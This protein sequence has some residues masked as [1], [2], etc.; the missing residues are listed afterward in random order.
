MRLTAQM[1]ALTCRFMDANRLQELETKVGALEG[2]V[3]SLRS[4]LERAK[5]ENTAP[6]S[7][8]P[9]T[10]DTIATKV[11]PPAPPPSLTLTQKAPT[12]QLRTESNT[13]FSWEWLIGGNIIGKVGIVTLI[14]STALFM[15]YALDQG[16]LSE[17]VRLIMLQGAFAALGFMSYRLY[18]KEYRY[19]PE[20]L[21]I[22]ALAA[23]TIAIYSAHFVYRFLGR[24]ETMAMMFALMAL[25]LLYARR[26]R[27]NAL[28]MIL[29]VAFFIL[30]IVHSRGINEAKIYFTYLT[31]VN[32]LFI[33]LN[34]LRG[35][36]NAHGIWI[37]LL[38]NT[39]SVLGW[40]NAYNEY[41]TTPL[42]FCGV[43]LAALLYAAHVAPWSQNSGKFFRPAAIISV[44]L[45]Y[46]TMIAS[47]VNLNRNFSADILAI[48]YIAQAAI[49]LIVLQ[50]LPERVR[51]APAA[52]FAVV[53][54]MALGIMLTMHGPAER[55]VVAL[56][57]LLAM[58]LAGKYNDGLLYYGSAAANGINLIALM[59]TLGHANDSWF[60]L[61]FQA[62]GFILYT[63]AAIYMRQKTF[64]PRYFNFG[65]VLTG[66]ALVASFIVVVSELQRIVTS[67]DARLLMITL[68]FSFYALVLLV[69]G[70]RRQKIWFRQAGLFFMGLAI[71]KFYFIDIWQWDKSVRII[72]GIIL[73]GSLVLISFYYEKFR[74]KFKELGAI[75]ILSGLALP[76]GSL[77]AVEK[78]KPHRY[79]FV[80]ELTTKGENLSSKTYGR[81][82]ID[83]DIYKSAGTN[84]LRLTYDGRIVP[85]A[86][87]AKKNGENDRIEKNISVASLVTS[88]DGENTSIYIFENLDRIP[89]SAVKLVF[90]END[91]TRE[92][93]IY[94]KAA[95]F[96]STNLLKTTTLTR[97]GGKPVSHVIDFAPTTGE[98]QLHVKNDDDAALTLSQFTAIS[99]PE[100]IVFRIPEKLNSDKKI[101]LYYGSEY[102]Q[103]PKYD[104]AESI[105][106]DATFAEFSLS[107][108]KPNSAHKL[109]LFDPPY[110]IWFFRSIFWLLLAIVAWRVYVL[111]R[112]QLQATP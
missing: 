88:V 16:W 25:A 69:I 71:A 103:K 11:N 28:A 112:K 38:G 109:T 75:L 70:F 91:Y 33:I 105:A 102:A 27:S 21:A 82:S 13:G 17:W 48:A 43:T 30:P 74:G 85:Y 26:I 89:M 8:T 83:T 51:H 24:S 94:Q 5:R 66:V 35:S 2:A 6:Q 4:E 87:Q 47:V 61:N 29:F 45:L 34:Y 106:E 77:D 41:A 54:L 79:K 36:T 50:F 95:R 9:S 23:N 101:I 76:M 55:I 44:N 63:V 62:G 46:M 31:A 64:W 73:G 78:F 111:Y 32:L 97:K 86:R 84:D 20:V 1:G 22:C 68:V 37:I 15:V 7:A 60:L 65:P 58:A 18:K 53:F 3:F 99:D 92:L 96:Q 49:N 81:F 52:A 10:L 80:K 14:L 59:T 104:V 39:L 93:G 110:S 19:I 40:S 67:K 108:Q 56:L 72:A 42:L 98:L 107:A 90:Q 100:Q 57:L 12:P